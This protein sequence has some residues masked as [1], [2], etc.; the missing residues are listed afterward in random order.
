M[1]RRPV[2]A[3]LAA[4]LLALALYAGARPLGPL[5]PLG[6]LLDPA[7]GLWAVASTAELPRS[8]SARVPGLSGRVEV[9]YDDRGVPHIFAATEEDAYRALGYVVARDR[10]FQLEIQTRAASGR[11]TE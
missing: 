7:N 11:L 8:A 9:R 2:P 5:P 10:L 3:A 1:S 4:L 6:P